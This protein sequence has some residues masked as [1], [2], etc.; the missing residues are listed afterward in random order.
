ME[1]TEQQGP[2]LSREILVVGGVIV[3]GAIM[4]A[5]VEA[6]ELGGGVIVGL[7]GLIALLWVRARRR[8][9]NG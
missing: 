5:M 4:F 3:L 7:A 6:A 1:A 2:V 9:G 8:F